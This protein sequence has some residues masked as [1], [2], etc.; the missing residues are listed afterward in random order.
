MCTSTELLL[1]QPHGHIYARIKTLV[2]L[3]HDHDKI[4]LRF[5]SPPNNDSKVWSDCNE[6]Q[7]MSSWCWEASQ[8]ETILLPLLRI[9]YTHWIIQYSLW[10]RVAR[11]SD[12]SPCR[13]WKI[14]TGHFVR[15]H[16]ARKLLLKERRVCSFAK[17][18]T[19][20]HR[21][22]PHITY[23]VY[24]THRFLPVELINWIDW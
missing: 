22:E 15:A 18:N 11:S 5:T 10:L 7:Y 1:N 9:F 20:A 23:T 17:Q 12:G 14:A 19:C 13:Q 16:F 8:K 6:T 21:C 3:H 24:T 2:I 4:R